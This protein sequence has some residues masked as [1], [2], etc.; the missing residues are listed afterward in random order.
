MKYTIALVAAANAVNV[1]QLE[2]LTIE[3]D[4]H[5]GDLDRGAAFGED[6]RF[7]DLDYG[8]GREGLDI[9]DLNYGYG[10]QIIYD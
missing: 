7:L 10:P 3:D 9:Y 1:Q 2:R 8:Y 5:L 6:L 4:Y